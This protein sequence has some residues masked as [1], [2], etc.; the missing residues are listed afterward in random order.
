M[1]SVL[2]IAA[3]F[4][5]S[6]Y[7]A[8]L[9]GETGTGKEELA[10]IIH[11]KSTRKKF[12]TVNCG[13]IPSGLLESELFGHEK[14]AFTGAQNNRKGRLEEAD[15][16]TLF[17]DEIGD[18]DITVQVKL[19]R[20]LQTGEIQRLGSDRTHQVDVRI[21][22]ATNRDISGLIE[23]GKFREDLY[24]WLAVCELHLQ[25]LRERPDERPMLLDAFLLRYSDALSKP[26][27]VLSTALRA[28]LLHTYDYPGNI[29]E[30]EN[31]AKLISALSKEG[32]ITGLS[33]L[34]FRYQR[35]GGQK[36][37]GNCGFALKTKKQSLEKEALTLALKE[38]KGIVENAAKSLFIST[39]RM[40]Q[41]LKAYSLSPALFREKK[42][43]IS[44][45]EKHA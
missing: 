28:H 38:H 42:E 15:K 24:Y 18:L 21:I 6:S 12:F 41:L 16:N 37:S 22:A 5:P 25:H 35:A 1:L 32:E 9:T 8:L 45:L 33:T 29:R 27:P 44:F 20:F 26:V 10:K 3:R 43:D 36:L 39:S 31:I 17:L 34:P 4:A 13:A 19:L 2:E 11:E 40:Y 30:L 7:P 23:S 14:G